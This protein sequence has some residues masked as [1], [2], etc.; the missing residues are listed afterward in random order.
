MKILYVIT[1]AEW[2]GAQ[3][4]LTDLAV[5]AKNQN[6]TAEV[7]FGADGV[8]DLGLRLK[9]LEIKTWPLERLKRNISPINDFLAILELAK[10]YRKIQPDIIHL[11]SSKAGVVGAWARIIAGAKLNKNVKLIYTAHGWVFNEPMNFFIKWFYFWLEKSTASIKDKIICVSE[12]DRQIALDYQVAP[13]EKLIAIHNGLDENAINFLPAAEARAAILDSPAT[14]TQLKN[15]LIIGTI[16]NF[17]PTKGLKYFIEAINLILTE[18]SWPLIAI[19]IGGGRERPALEKLIGQKKLT[20]KIFLIG[21]KENAAN[22]LKAFDIY[23][24]SSVKEGLPYSILEAMAAGR[25]I[26]TTKVGGVP[27]MIEEEKTGLLAEPRSNRDLADKIKRLLNNQNYARQLG[28]N[29]ANTVREKFNL[30][31]MKEKTFKQYQN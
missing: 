26:I 24:C 7:A 17:Y 28:A 31:Q 1:Q 16:A 2:G 8:N 18:K 12:F 25:P 3:K 6:W 29:A 15:N 10:L 4:Y 5:A 23:I 21:Q 11:N 30:N 13:A 9:A 19:I 20:E 14:L 22:Y 27:E